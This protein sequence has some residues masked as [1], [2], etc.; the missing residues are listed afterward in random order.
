MNEHWTPDEIR[1]HLVG[2]WK[3][4]SA[5]GAGGIHEQ[6]YRFFPDGTWKYSSE[7]SLTVRESPVFDRESS[8]VVQYHSDASTGGGNRYK[9]TDSGE[10][11]LYYE[12]GGENHIGKLEIAKQGDI[13][14]GNVWYSKF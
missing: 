11:I 6:G 8:S 5:G 12:S 4:V 3:G 7:S 9:V 14:I 1:E 10:L 2:T 13:E